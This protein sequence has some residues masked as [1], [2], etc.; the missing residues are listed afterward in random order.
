MTKK[1][2]KKIEK[3]APKITLPKVDESKIQ[4]Y[5][6]GGVIKKNIKKKK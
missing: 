3:K 5:G 1:P 2:D 6:N 4:T